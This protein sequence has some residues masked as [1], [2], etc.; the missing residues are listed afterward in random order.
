MALNLGSAIAYLKLD[1]TDFN[2]NLDASNNKLVSIG[3]K[4]GKGISIVSAAVVTGMVAVGKSSI[5]AG[6]QFDSSMSQVAATLGTTVDQ[7]QE[8]SDFALE[9]GAT[10]AFSASQAAD[11]LNYMALAGYDAETSMSMLPTVLNLA[12]AGGIDLARASDMVTDAQSAL[13][14]SL[15]E[16]ESLI[17][18]MA[19]TASKSNTSVEQLGEAILTIGGTA[20]I[21]AG[22]TERLNTVL[23]IL[24]DNGIKGSEAGTHLRNMLLRLSA[25][26]KEGADAIEALGLQVFDAEGKMRDMEDIILDLGNAMVDLTDDQRIKYISDIFNARD[27]AAANA[28]LNTS[29]DRWQE[30]GGAI[31]DSKEAAQAMAETQLDNLE[32]DITL[33]KSAL[34]GAEITIS[35]QLTP[36]LRKFIQFG[37]KEIGKLDTAFQ[38]GG[39]N[40]LADQFGKSLANATKRISDYIPKIINV[41]GKLIS[42]FIT[43]IGKALPSLSTRISKY[44][45]KLLTE[46]GRFFTKQLPSFVKNIGES[47]GRF[48]VNAPEIVSA[49]LKMVTGL[50]KGVLQG[51]PNLISGLVK[52]FTDGMDE[53]SRVVSDHVQE[54][55]D[56][57]ES[58][59]SAVD[60]VNESLADINA[61][62]AEAEHWIDIFER[63]SEKENPTIQDTNNLRIAVDKLNDL[64]PD[65]DLHIDENTGKWSLNTEEI[66]NNIAAL[67]DKAR[68]EAY[69]DAAG[70]LYKEIAA[71]ELEAEKERDAKKAALERRDE[72]ERETGATGDL[73]TKLS[74]LYD[75][76][77]RGELTSAE[78]KEKLAQ[79]VPDVVLEDA[80]DL[81]QY[82][83]VLNQ[84]WQESKDDF[85]EADK[86]YHDVAAGVAEYEKAIEALEEDIDWLYK[87]GTEYTDAATESMSNSFDK[88]VVRAKDAGGETGRAYVDEIVSEVESGKNKV[89]NA[90]QRLVN[91]ALSVFS[92]GFSNGMNSYLSRATGRSEASYATGLA[93]VPRTMDVTVHRGERI[94]TQE[95][96][97]KYNEGGSVEIVTYQNDE[98][99]NA[100]GSK[101]D[102]ILD[103]IDKID[104]LQM[105]VDGKKLVGAIKREMN[106]QLADEYAT[107]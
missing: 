43:S 26:S 10:T 75:E 29:K 80:S 99:L 78:L 68:A 49:G 34:E 51:I 44:I 2:T 40:G 13:G 87:K 93:Y 21:M 46:L 36:T 25:P 65:L 5:E 74:D 62:Q 12:A 89:S 106:R 30:L 71:L 56:S 84:K 6:K 48:L 97:K 32:G 31:V 57:I 73:I 17:D 14:L 66:R 9:M 107:T 96:N 47:L 3:K 86:V 82:L 35:K 20:D 22:G 95:E 103:A 79:L 23:G 70:E 72:L 15:D 92:K 60:L 98:A 42:S 19:K 88:S 1:N 81:A 77:N 101:L 91:S 39:I 55:R 94:L 52:G 24:A 100:L 33:F 50:I 18:Q 7:I 38:K 90:A 53:S 28:L 61:K 63:L 64:F 104:D 58:I 85:A 41:G 102:K 37:T 76:F 45:P 11:A 4:I 8:L 54:I 59:P 67:Q 16:T 83:S 69:I 105:L 27:I